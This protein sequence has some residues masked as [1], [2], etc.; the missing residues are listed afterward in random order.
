MWA[1]WCGPCIETIPAW[2]KLLQQYDPKLIQFITVSMDTEV[3][4][5]KRSIAQHKP[6]G[7]ALI[8]PRSFNSLFAVYCK[9]LWVSHYVIADPTG[10][11]VNYDA[12]HPDD[13][14]F[15]QIIDNLI[16]KQSE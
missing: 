2:N 9:A 1:S 5:W 8:E 13:P 12:P 14:E 15:R 4:S 11:I 16:K 7:L 6:G 10:H 3:E